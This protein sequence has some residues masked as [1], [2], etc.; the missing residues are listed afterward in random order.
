DH[1]DR[2]QIKAK[3]CGVDRA[4]DVPASQV[5]KQ[6]LGGVEA[7]GLLCFHRACTQMRRHEHLGVFAKWAVRIKRFGFKNVQCCATHLATVQ[8]GDQVV[9]VDH[10]ASAVVDEHDTLLAQAKRFGREKVA[11]LLI[12]GDVEGQYVG[13][14]E[15]LQHVGEHAHLA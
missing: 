4:L 10:A 5:I 14:G 1:L 6:A 8:C 2:I 11:G 15:H 12:E 7:H 3:T 13:F 9:L